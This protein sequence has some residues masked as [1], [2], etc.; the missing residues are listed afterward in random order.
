MNQ[1]QQR[2]LPTQIQQQQPSMTIKPVVTPQY[3]VH[4]Q[5][6]Q[7]NAPN[8]LLQSLLF[9]HQPQQPEVNKKTKKRSFSI[10]FFSSQ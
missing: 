5:Q 3:A 10:L 9:H 7:I 1:Q 4:Q 6:H 2:I 8:I